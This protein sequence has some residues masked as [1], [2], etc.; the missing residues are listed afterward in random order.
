MGVNRGFAYQET[1]YCLHVHTPMHIQWSF[2]VYKI[3]C[4]RCSSEHSMESLAH[5]LTSV[6]VAGFMGKI[7]LPQYV[8]S[9]S[10]SGI[11]GEQLLKA[12]PDMLIELGVISPLHQMKI[13]QLFRYHIA[14]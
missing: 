8:D 11:G 7:G 2:S 4:F 10:V 14:L 3:K 1:Y 13:M 9:F 5:K 6:D 12:D